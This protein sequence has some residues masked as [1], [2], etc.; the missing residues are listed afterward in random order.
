MTCSVDGCS[1]LPVTQ[2]VG[3]RLRVDITQVLSVGGF[4]PPTGAAGEMPELSIKP[5][6]GAPLLILLQ[7][8][9]LKYFSQ[10]NIFTRQR[11]FEIIVY[12]LLCELPLAIEPH[13]SVCH[14]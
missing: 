12:L 14:L 7:G 1:I 4:L 9:L 10:G 5:P 3:T 6:L 8:Y 11:T 2:F 13:M